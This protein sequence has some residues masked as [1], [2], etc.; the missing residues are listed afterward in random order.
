MTDVLA[1]IGG[2]SWGTALALVLAARF[3][4][5][6]LWVREPEIVSCIR[7]NRENSVYLPGFP[8][9]PA[10]LPT[11]EI[12][13]ALDGAGIVLSVVPSTHVREIYRRM[14]PW[15]R[16]EM[17]LVS[18]TKGLENQSLLRMTQVIREVLPFPAVV[19]ALSGPSFAREV[20][21]GAPTAIV[22]AS[23][24]LGL[25]KAIQ[26]A[27]SGPTLRLYTNADVIGVELGG[28]LKNVIAIGAGVCQ[29]LGLGPNA[30]AALVTRGL[31]E[32]TRLSVAMGGDP[33][34]LAGLA[35]MGDLVLT[36]H[37]ELSR[38]RMVGIELA[39]GRKLSDI[40]G[41]MTMVAEGIETTRAAVE[42][43]GRHQVEMPIAEQMHAMLHLGRS[44]AE[45]IRI[46]MERN[47]KRE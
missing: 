4:R 21:R 7:S 16:P 45:A 14:A 23:E 28:A 8:L 13:E 15:I 37:G 38:N 43:A 11:A 9:P 26:H 5:V 12:A 42:L 30:L 10:V 33:R 36:C 41:S 31:A 3:Q 17:R 25:A 27:C 44:P 32:M 1:V 20:A 35:G 46:L 47:L 6:N 29:G 2:G 40:V 18:A 19:A 24:D 34:T 22:V 39:K